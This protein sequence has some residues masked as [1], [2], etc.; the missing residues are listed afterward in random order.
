VFPTSPGD[1]D[2][3]LDQGL[4]T[5]DTLPPFHCLFIIE[6]LESMSSLISSAMD[7][8][9][10]TTAASSLTLAIFTAS[11]Y[12]HD[13]IEIA[14]NVDQRV[15]DLAAS[16]DALLAILQAMKNVFDTPG[17]QAI[18][19]N[20]KDIGTL[21]GAVKTSIDDCMATAK[22]VESIFE[23]VAK[24]KGDS[25]TLLAKGF[26]Q[27]K[28]QQRQPDIDKLNNLIQQHKTNMQLSLQTVNVWVTAKA[29]QIQVS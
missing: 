2:A 11:K 7:P 6:S 21:L 4:D 15:K 24:E 25:K 1:R 23:V 26:R 14:K 27:F 18:L 22:E 9:S 8:L 17:T 13:F 19:K 12:I 5:S 3:V 10:I 20:A 16:V 28:M 29:W